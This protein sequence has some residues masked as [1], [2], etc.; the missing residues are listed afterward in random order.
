[1]GWYY[2]HLKKSQGDELYMQQEYPCDDV[3]AWISSG[4][5]IFPG[6]QLEAYRKQCRPGM[7]FH[8]WRSDVRSS[9]EIMHFSVVDDLHLDDDIKRDS[10]NYIEV[11]QRPIP[12]RRYAI[13]ADGSAGFA[14]SDYSSAFVI[15][16]LTLEMVAEIHAKVEPS[17]FAILL[18]SMGHYYNDAVIAPETNGMGLT[19][20]SHLKEKYWNIYFRREEGPKGY[21]ITDKM[22][23]E[24]TT[25]T[26]PGLI[27]NAKRLFLERARQGD[28]MGEFI[29]SAELVKEL[30]SF[31]MGKGG[32]P[33]AAGGCHDDRVIAW[34]ITLVAIFHELY[35][36]IAKED[37]ALPNTVTVTHD[38]KNQ[39]MEDV[40][41]AI[42]DWASPIQ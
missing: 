22:G 10:E 34:A 2:M 39:R 28:R 14:K 3:E 26:R 23:W 32:K 38:E 21:K 42:L 19:V 11:W 24:T 25:A 5:P 30:Q 31:V 35:N 37:G 18:R 16:M 27:T 33:E 12:K 40:M 29:R 13:G 20:L 7:L 4:T 15:D 41:E 8:V 9:K 36:T 17:D 6:K 1:M